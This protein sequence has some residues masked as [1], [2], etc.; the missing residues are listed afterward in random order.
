MGKLNPHLCDPKLFE[1]DLSGQVIIV[2]GA[3]SGVGL[4]T[5]RQ[6]TKQGARVVLACRRPEAG[7]ATAKELGDNATFIKLDLN[8]LKSVRDFVEEFKGKFD[9]LDVLV[10]N[11]GI[12]AGP[13]KKTEDG[14]ES[15]FG[16]NHLAHFLLFLLLAPMLESTA[17]Q[18]GSPSRLIALS[19]SASISVPTSMGAEGAK[20]RSRIY[21]D[22]MNWETMKYQ[23]W[24][25]YQQAK[26]ANY[27][28][29]VEVA[30]RYDSDKIV[31]YAI[32]PGFVQ[33]NLA[34]HM[35]P[36][37]FIG[38]MMTKM[39]YKFDSLSIPSNLGCHTS[40]HCILSDV[41]DL[42]NGAYYSQTGP[43]ETKEL[44]KG[45]WPLDVKSLNENMTDEAASRLWDESVKL[46][47]E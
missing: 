19:S 39:Y 45:G 22:D 24:R 18:T 37:G 27:L 10:N 32:H 21:F 43:Y 28:H 44:R 26:L 36:K 35:M 31:S 34:G 40:L 2:T 41:A 12:M 46:V 1:K 11:A 14:F 38:D 9:R 6:L 8:S 16:C 23:P 13:Y 29:A 33:S 25:A 17:E 3:N 20:H 15:Q 5:S 42:E 7:E 4:E 47:G 30:K